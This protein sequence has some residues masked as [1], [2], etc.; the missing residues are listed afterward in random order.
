MS[1]ANW[2]QK[3]EG[4]IAPLKLKGLK[5][6]RRPEAVPFGPPQFLADQDSGLFYLSS[7]RVSAEILRITQ[8]IDWPRG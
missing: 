8:M 2:K 7:G 4:E 5:T 1:R 3:A 6:E